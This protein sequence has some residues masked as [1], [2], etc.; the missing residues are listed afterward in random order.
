MISCFMSATNCTLA[1]NYIND[2]YFISNKQPGYNFW[3]KAPSL[4]WLMFSL[5]HIKAEIN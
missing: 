1:L 3:K 2:C 4:N 5:A